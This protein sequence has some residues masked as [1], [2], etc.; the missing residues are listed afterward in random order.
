MYA[1]GGECIRSF[2]RFIGASFYFVDDV[3]CVAVG[4]SVGGS[5]LTSSNSDSDE[6][7]IVVDGMKLL[8]NRQYNGKNT[9]QTKFGRAWNDGGRTSPKRSKR[10]K[11]SSIA[12]TRFEGT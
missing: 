10:S 6:E 9:S 3:V 4:K 8:T 5:S 12:A 11:E 1:I 7:P 2:V